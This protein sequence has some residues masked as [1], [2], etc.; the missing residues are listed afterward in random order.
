MNAKTIS[1]G[2]MMLAK[3]VPVTLESGTVKIMTMDTRMDRINNN[4]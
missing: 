1:K 4:G 2:T 3:V